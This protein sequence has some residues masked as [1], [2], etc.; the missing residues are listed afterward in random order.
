MEKFLNKLKQKNIPWSKDVNLTELKKGYSRISNILQ[1][2]NLIPELSPQQFFRLTKGHTQKYYSVC[3]DK[4]QDKKYFFRSLVNLKLIQNSDFARE[5]QL[6][7]IIKNSAVPFKKYLLN[8]IKFSTDINLPWILLEY[9]D[10]TTVLED[11]DRRG[12]LT[13][14]LTDAE[15]QLLVNVI[16]ELQTV[17]LDIIQNKLSIPTFNIVNSLYNQISEKYYQNK[18]IHTLLDES[19]FKISLDIIKKNEQLISEESKYPTHGDFYSGNIFINTSNQNAQIRIVDWE[20]FHINN[21]AYDITF[22]Y[23]HLFKEDD[24]ANRITAEYRKQLSLGLHNKFDRLFKLNLIYLC[25]KSL[26]MDT[27]YDYSKKEAVQKRNGLKK[28]LIR[29]INQ[30]NL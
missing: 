22:F 27:F 4:N 8:Y 19:S 11:K 1:S 23:V 9:L 26:V 13:R 3:A 18:S 5:I 14:T 20:N 29:T 7:Q 28:M 30:M 21:F 2:L 25:L 10:T 15:I 16:N 17:P 12:R 24:F 6:M